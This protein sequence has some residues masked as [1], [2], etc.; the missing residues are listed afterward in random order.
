MRGHFRVKSVSYSLQDSVHIAHDFAVPESKDPIIVPEQPLIACLVLLAICVLTAVDLQDQS[1][2][3]A[4]KI[5]NITADRL[6]PDEF[7]SVGGP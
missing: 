1:F 4:D 3:A 2:F 7:V 5:N 6:L